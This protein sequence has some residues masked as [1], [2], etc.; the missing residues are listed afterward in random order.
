MIHSFK[1]YILFTF[2]LGFT[3]E[4]CF[5]QDSAMVSKIKQYSKKA[6]NYLD[7]ESKLFPY[8]AI[9]AN[10]ISIYESPQ[11]KLVGKSEFHLTWDKMD[12]FN[13]YIKNCPTQQVLEIY[14]KGDCDNLTPCLSVIKKSSLI[15][16]QIIS[17]DKKR[18]NG[19]KIAIDA[20][21]IA[22]DMEMGIIEKKC[23]TFQCTDSKGSMDSISIV[24]GM[25]TFATAKL[26]KDKL[27]TEGAE[28]LMT[29]T[30]NNGSSFGLT[31]DDW[32]KIN[33]KT[34]VDSLFKVGKLTLAQKQFFLSPK[35]SKRDK[36]RVIFK[37]IEL[38]KRAEIINNYKPDFTI[39]IHYN[40]DETNTGWTKTATKNFNMTF[41][42]GAF[43]KDDLSTLEKRFEFFRLLISKDMEQSIAL[44]SAVVKSFEKNLNVKT[45]ALK[46]ATYLVEGCLTTGEPGV[47]CRNL[48]LTRYIH[49]PLVYGESLYQDNMKE[50]ISLNKECDKTKNERVQKVA[51]AYFQGILNYV[52][53]LDSN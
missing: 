20:G 25:L 48:Q 45:A 19:M 11:N 36:F 53:N 40:V 31:F 52:K 18:L 9:N 34:T 24:E 39:I 43:M 50:C 49:S 26:L 33:Y 6:E 2:L 15:G 1:L 12:D 28:V 23:L 10:G 22:G 14:K 46:D 30:F 29:R 3:I 13:G 32:L 37:D 4:N 42:G 41:V 16:N 38:G 27:E 5:S 47:Y 35:A 7:K 51:E 44:S 21:H 17:T 8:Y